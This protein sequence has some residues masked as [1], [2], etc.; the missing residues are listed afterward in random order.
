MPGWEVDPNEEARRR[1]LEGPYGMED[2]SVPEPSA[3]TGPYGIGPVDALREHQEAPRQGMKQGPAQAEAATGID[4]YG[5]PED[6]DLGPAPKR[7]VMGSYYPGFRGGTGLI[8][9]LTRMKA[10]S[11]YA[12]KHAEY[13]DAM[14]AR[15]E[16]EKRYNRDYTAAERREN[17]ARLE[18]GEKSLR[19]DR[20][21]DNARLSEKESEERE[22]A[23]TKLEADI[24]NQEEDNDRADEAAFD[25][26]RVAERKAT[27]PGNDRVTSGGGRAPSTSKSTGPK[28]YPKLWDQ[29]VVE[30]SRGKA[31]DEFG[32]S[33][34]PTTAEITAQYN[35][36]KA[37][38]GVDGSDLNPVGA[39]AGVG[40]QVSDEAAQQLEGKRVRNKRTNKWGVIRNGKFVPEQTA[41]P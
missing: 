25:R 21:A 30:A 16:K 29:A 1:A 12:A 32:Q 20:E 13:E 40:Q 10:E 26:R 18:R 19:E 41:G 24:L 31:T 36:L 28:F 6:L 15:E 38:A 3:D 27:T 23:E 33:E 11:D 14:S 35:S 7:P 2:Y 17:R 4:P 37:A 5:Y 34:P 8:S 39:S 22:R 9:R